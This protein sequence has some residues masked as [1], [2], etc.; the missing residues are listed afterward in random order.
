M[1]T[2]VMRYQKQTLE[3]LTVFK[4]SIYCANFDSTNISFMTFQY[5][6][7]KLTIYGS[8]SYVH[9]LWKS[10]SKVMKAAAFSIFTLVF[11]EIANMNTKHIPSDSSLGKNTDENMMFGKKI[12]T[13]V[14]LQKERKNNFGP[15]VF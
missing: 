6:L 3:Q 11:E 8:S 1:Q 4:E 2:A 7:D 13:V 15:R 14:T 5:P 10:I 12:D 9:M